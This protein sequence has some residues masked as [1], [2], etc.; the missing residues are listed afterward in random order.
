MTSSVVTAQSGYN[1]LRLRLKPVGLGVLSGAEPEYLKRWLPKNGSFACGPQW[2]YGGL[3]LVL[4]FSVNVLFLSI[5]L[6]SFHP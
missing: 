2:S 5:S 1:R 6:F 3:R 4:V